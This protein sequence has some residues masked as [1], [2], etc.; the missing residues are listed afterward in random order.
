MKNLKISL[1]INILVVILTII[2]SI[3]MFTGFKFM[4]DYELVLETT[5]IGMFKFFTV[6]S[7]IFMGVI[8]L[9]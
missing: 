1:V 9:Y 6:Q 5:K 8:A 4:P 2:S 7:N 3:I